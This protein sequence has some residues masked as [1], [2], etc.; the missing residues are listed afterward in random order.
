[1]SGKQQLDIPV[2]YDARGLSTGV[3]AEEES[4]D[5]LI[6]EPF[7][8]AKID[9]Q[10]RS[11]TVDL[12]LARLRRGV[13][14]LAPDFQRFAGIWSEVA[15][16]KLIES[17]L[18]RIPLPTLYA[19]ESGEDSWVI[20]D[21]IQRLTTIARFVAPEVIGA[22]PLTLSGLEYLQNYE[23][24][25]YA[26]LPGALQTRIDETELII[27]LIRAGT[28]EPVKFNI[29]A[30]IN[31]GGRAL[32]LQELR[33]A[34]IPG[35]AR[36]LLMKLA[37]SEPFLEATL[38]SVKKDRMA[39]REMVLRFLAFRL[40]EPTDY[41]RGDLDIFLRQTM[42]RINSLSPGAIEDLTLDFER[43]MWA[44]H[45]IFREHAFRKTFQGQERRLPINKA[46]FEAVSVN[47]AKLTPEKIAILEAR[48]R[49]VQK[50]L[51]T[52]MEDSKF[53]QAI[54]VGTGDVEKVR[55]RFRAMETLFREVIR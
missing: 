44:A 12:L 37:D 42:K 53:Q 51:M 20:V 35:Q 27:H 39:D 48:Q 33:H 3:E 30:R 5:G 31:T 47:L 24:Y 49:T 17:L 11:M 13:L 19:A 2:E 6:H 45:K 32:T 7:D 52:L 14:D 16:S 46:L 26:E 41:P 10:T 43:A 36:E 38:R 40:T 28:P 50:R 18:L 8:P 25:K 22:D 1:V 15:Q 9:V 55:R 4:Q 54:S 21:G 34:L 23:G 29:F